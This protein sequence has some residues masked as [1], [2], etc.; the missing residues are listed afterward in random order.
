MKNNYIKL[1]NE[2]FNQ[3]R[4][5]GAT[6]E[7]FWE[8]KFESLMETDSVHKYDDIVEW[9]R[10][11]VRNTNM[12]VQ[13][14][15]LS[16]CR[17]WS[18]GSRSNAIEHD[19][20]AFYSV[21]GYRVSGSNTREVQSGWDQP[22]LT[23][24][25]FDGGILGL[26][27]KRMNS[28]PHYLVEAKEEPGNYNFVQLSSS[29]QATFSNMYRKHKGRAPHFVHIF[30]NPDEY[31]VEVIFDQWTSEDGGRLFNKRNR[32]MLIDIPESL[33]IEKPSERFRWLTL[34]QIKR[35]INEE[36][37]IVAPHIRGIL[38]GL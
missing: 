11:L 6:N 30:T 5:L 27:R 10:F 9:Y 19:S 23:Q 33:E 4:D 26:L 7:K 28:V 2:F 15:P 13:E 12:S 25:G 36:N 22:L 20:R 24:V 31:N 29:L 21:R 35:L 17:H 38:S 14:I 18:I 1:R 8:F 16:E 3:L 37:A 32:S 34:F